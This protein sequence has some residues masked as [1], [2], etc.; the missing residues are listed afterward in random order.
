MRLKNIKNNVMELEKENIAENKE[1]V[2]LK[3][4]KGNKS[5]YDI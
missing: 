4:F 5:N 2:L 3:K 1:N